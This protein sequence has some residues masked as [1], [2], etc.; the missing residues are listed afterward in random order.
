MSLA[1]L[2]RLNKEQRKKVNIVALFALI[3]IGTLVGG[4]FLS[5][6]GGVRDINDYGII[7]VHSLYGGAGGGGL[8]PAISSGDTIVAED[9][10]AIVWRPDPNYSGSPTCELYSTDGTWYESGNWNLNTNVDPYFHLWGFTLEGV[11]TGTNEFYCAFGGSYTEDILWVGSTIHFNI[12]SGTTPTHPAVIFEVVPDPEP[13]PSGTSTPLKWH[14]IYEG[15]ATA[16]VYVDGVVKS[17]RDTTPSDGTQYFTYSFSETVVGIYIVK[18]T[19]DPE[20]GLTTSSEIEVEVIE[21]SLVYDDAVIK[22]KPADVS[23]DF[24]VDESVA[25]VIWMFSYDG[26]CIADVRLADGTEVDSQTYIAS[27]ND[28]MFDY[29]VDTSVAG[30]Y[31]L[32]LTVIP[33]DYNNI[34][35]VDS[36]TVTVEASTT[37]PTDTTPTVLP[38]DEMVLIMTMVG[39]AAGIILVGILFVK[40]GAIPKKKQMN[41]GETK[42]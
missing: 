2:K 32:I 41:K 40:G 11:P 27:T 37:T 21:V 30:T 3:V 29:I 8:G 1:K 6:L 4:M 9:G 20:Y 38:P 18:L 23:F 15:L 33:D 14:F 34:P 22:V 10:L 35:V 7:T 39:V 25:H 28:K 17:T 16:T 24:D 26:P 5:P 42:I 31:E 36:V 12:Q 19:I 13:I